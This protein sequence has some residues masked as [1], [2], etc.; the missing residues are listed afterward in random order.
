MLGARTSPSRPE[1]EARIGFRIDFSSKFPE[2]A[3]WNMRTGVSALPASSGTFQM[4][5]NFWG[6]A[7]AD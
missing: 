2:R 3:V 4:P 7:R 5:I 1:R 6:K